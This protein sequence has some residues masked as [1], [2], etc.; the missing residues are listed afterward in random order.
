M[1]ISIYS[2]ITYIPYITPHRPLREGGLA[3]TATLPLAPKTREL[4]EFHHGYLTVHRCLR[5]TVTRNSTVILLITI[6]PF[7]FRFT[8]KQSGTLSA[9]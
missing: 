4:G 1:N 3:A 5:I 8:I 9:A 2:K 7:P 6:E